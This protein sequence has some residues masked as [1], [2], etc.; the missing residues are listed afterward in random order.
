MRKLTKMLLGAVLGLLVA[1]ALAG[2][3]APAPPPTP[4]PV[5]SEFVVNIVT[6]NSQTS[7][8]LKSR[9]RYALPGTRT[10]VTFAT[11]LPLPCELQAMILSW[12][13]VFC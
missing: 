2:E 5:G 1:F 11:I 6:A 4:A 12:P 3:A 8:L 10:V 7:L 9:W 13:R